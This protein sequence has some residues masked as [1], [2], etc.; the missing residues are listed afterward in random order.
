M[1]MKTVCDDNIHAAQ[2][3]SQWFSKRRR[4]KPGRFKHFW[5]WVHG[6]PQCVYPARSVAHYFL[7]CF[8]GGERDNHTLKKPKFEKAVR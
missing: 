8:T 7:L 4:N 5:T 2:A 6:V 3:V 1:K